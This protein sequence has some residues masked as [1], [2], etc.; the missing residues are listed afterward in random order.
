MYA[1]LRINI[2]LNEEF[3]NSNGVKTTIYSFPM[4]FIPLNAK[5]RD[6]DTGNGN[7]N[8]RYLR[9]MQ[10]ILNVT[11]GPVMP[12]KE[13]FLQAFGRDAEEFKAIL[14]MPDEFIRNRLVPN[15]RQYS[16]YEQRLMPYV[17]GWMEG[18]KGLSQGEKALLVQVIGTN[19]KQLIKKAY[20]GAD[21][22]NLEKMFRYHIEENE[23]IAGYKYG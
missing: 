7:W 13:F 20:H 23:I 8:K 21:N 9:G 22:N 19:D 12:G 3:R 10:V 4:R 15:W 6:V 17:R 11:K 2:D 1:R 5:R 14:L 18:Y 16:D